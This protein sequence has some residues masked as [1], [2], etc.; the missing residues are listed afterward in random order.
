ME[1]YEWKRGYASIIIAVFFIISFIAA[2]TCIDGMA[3]GYA[4]AFVSFFIA[5]WALRLPHYL[6]TVPGS[7]MQF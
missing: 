2:L 7:W 6:S 5:L 3:G 4:I 1:N